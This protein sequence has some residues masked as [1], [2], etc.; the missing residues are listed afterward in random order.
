MWTEKEIEI[1]L[2]DTEY[3]INELIDGK[4]ERFQKSRFKSRSALIGKR[5]VRVSFE[6]KMRM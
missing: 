1:F 5:H 3:I 4:Y 6:K 2:N